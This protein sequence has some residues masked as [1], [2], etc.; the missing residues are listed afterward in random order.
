MAI[1]VKNESDIGLQIGEDYKKVKN[2]DEFNVTYKGV[3][4]EKKCSYEKRINFLHRAA[5]GFLAV[6]GKISIYLGITKKSSNG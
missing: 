5:I 1:R 6:L 3:K 2:K 4:Y